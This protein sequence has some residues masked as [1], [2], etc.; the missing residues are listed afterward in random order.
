MPKKSASVIKVTKPVKTAASRVKATRLPVA[1]P[2]RTFLNRVGSNPFK[3][4]PR[5]FVLPI[6]GGLILLSLA[7]LANRYLVIAWVDN[8]PITKFELLSAL[9]QKYGQDLREQLI[10]ERLIESEA[11]KRGV[12]VSGQ[13]LNSQIKKIEDEQG[14]ADKLNQILQLQGLSQSEFKKLVRL[15]IMR[16]KM[17]GQGVT[18]SDDEVN[19]YI[20]QNKANLPGTNNDASSEAKLKDNVRE[21]LRQQKINASFSS[22]LRDNLKSSRVQRSQ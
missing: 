14:G 20:E 1:A 13:E 2:V 7:Y 9:D 15:Q 4:A 19:R 6:L 12:T 16:E 8:K 21:Q 18:V 22:W 10:V 5:R 17:F 3:A 11:G